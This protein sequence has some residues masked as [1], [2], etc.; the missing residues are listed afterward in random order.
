[1]KDTI[2]FAYTTLIKFLSYDVF[3]HKRRH[4]IQSTT[5]RKL[6]KMDFRIEDIHRHWVRIEIENL[7]PAD[8]FFAS[9]CVLAYK[10]CEWLLQIFQNL[11][12]KGNECFEGI[13]CSNTWTLY[14]EEVIFYLIIL[15][16]W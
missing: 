13:A 6:E 10:I 8:E 2:F 4:A 1:M 12:K 14:G 15:F 7:S 16:S 3:S 5:D 11:F 9:R